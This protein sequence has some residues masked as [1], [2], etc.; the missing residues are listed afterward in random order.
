MTI[1]ICIHLHKTENYIQANHLPWDFIGFYIGLSALLFVY[2]GVI[3]PH[4]WIMG[5][6]YWFAGSV[7]FCNSHVLYI[8][9]VSYWR[10][11]LLPQLPSCVSLE[12]L[13]GQFC[14]WLGCTTHDG[15]LRC[16]AA[17][18]LTI[19]VTA[20]VT[21]GLKSTHLFPNHYSLHRVSSVVV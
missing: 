7:S 20:H 15:P 13:Q 18:T 1:L 8:A 12:W 2:F 16:T 14:Y 4:S 9:G 17:C 19:A 21:F 3:R 5:D 6:V 10:V 11:F